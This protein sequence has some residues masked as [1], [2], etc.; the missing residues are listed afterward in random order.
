MTCPPCGAGDP[1]RRAGTLAGA[2]ILARHGTPG[3][4]M[5][6]DAAGGIARATIFVSS[7]HGLTSDTPPGLPQ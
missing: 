1:A 3:V 7:R 5:I 2:W 4:G 6:A